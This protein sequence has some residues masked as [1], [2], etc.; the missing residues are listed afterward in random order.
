MTRGE[1]LRQ[2]RKASGATL[3]QA[4]KDCEITKSYLWGLEHE[5]AP[6]L[7]LTIA[8]RLMDYYGGSIR[9]FSRLPV[10]EPPHEATR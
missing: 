6:G 9:I 7:S 4:S 1:C 8:T 10:T 2:L 5:K 3:G